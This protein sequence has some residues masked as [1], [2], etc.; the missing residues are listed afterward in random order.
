MTCGC[1]DDDKDEDQPDSEQNEYQCLDES[2]SIAFVAV[3]VKIV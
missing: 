2:K 3:P 1:D